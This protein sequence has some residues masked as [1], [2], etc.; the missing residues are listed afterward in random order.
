M[1]G[2]LSNRISV[3]PTLILAR[4]Y[5]FYVPSSSDNSRASI[6]GSTCSAADRS[7]LFA[8]FTA[9]MTE[10]VD[11]IATVPTQGA[12]DGTSFTMSSEPASWIA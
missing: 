2:R 6:C 7:T 12:R 5:H 9:T 10:S 1:Y 8:G 11:V 4:E 3:Q